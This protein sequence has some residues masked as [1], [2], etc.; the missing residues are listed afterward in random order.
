MNGTLTDIYTIWEIV[1]HE[2]SAT[3][4]MACGRK[5]KENDTY[6]DARIEHGIAKNGYVN[7]N[8]YNVDFVGKA[9]NQL[10]K[11][12]ID[13]GSK[14]TNL[15]VKFDSEPRW[16]NEYTNKSGEKITAHVDYPKTPKIKVFE[17]ELPEANPSRTNLDKAPIV[18]TEE[19]KQEYPF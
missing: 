11:Y 13:E 7:T 10:K 4:R 9:Y 14:I 5:V 2:K 16:L 12:E 6:D 19:I 3:I 8:F 17:F 15:K 18:E 1:D